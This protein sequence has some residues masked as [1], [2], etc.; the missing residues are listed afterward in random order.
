MRALARRHAARHIENV[1]SCIAIHDCAHRCCWRLSSAFA[2]AQVTFQNKIGG[3]CQKLSE[4]SNNR[5][6]LIKMVGK[7]N[8]K[9]IS[10]N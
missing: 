5:A 9:L 7:T 1:P 8:L 4:G 2:R 6:T 3:A 10:T